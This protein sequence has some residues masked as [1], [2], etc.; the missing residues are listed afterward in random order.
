M[1]MI[2]QAHPLLIGSVPVGSGRGRIGIT[3]CPGKKQKRAASGSW[4]CHLPSDLDAIQQWG[5]A[6]VVTLLEDHELEALGVP[7]IGAEVRRRHM[8]WVHLPIADGETPCP[9]FDREWE[10]RGEDLRA[11]LRAGFDVLVHCKGGF[12]RAGTIAAK[13]LVELD[14]DPDSAIAAVRAARPEAIETAAQAAYVRIAYSWGGPIPS[15]SPQARHDRARGALIGLAVGD[16]LGTTLKLRARDTYPA[17][18]EIIGGG[19]FCLKP[20]QWTD[21]TAMALA[22]ADSLL[23]APDLDER[24]LMTRFTRW[25]EHGTYSC[26]GSCFDVGATVSQA[27]WRW[28]K[29][30]NPVSGSKDPM[31]A[32]NGALMRL[33][34]VAIRHWG[35]GEKLVAVARRQT[36]TTHGAEEALGASTYFA[37]LL[38]EAIEGTDRR[39]QIL[40]P[41]D[42]DEPPAL[43]AVIGGSWRGKARGSIQSSGYVVHSLEAALWAVGRTWSFRDAVLLA[44]NLGD[45]TDSVAAI[46]GQL[47]GAL[48]GYSGIPR[49]W[50]ERLKWRDKLELAADHLFEEGLGAKLSRPEDWHEG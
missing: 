34:P 29:F 13:L 32:G 14:H 12:G 17:L 30:G 33:A 27:L 39:D 47:A 20:G 25:R 44:A 3:F 45:D 18:E 19:P 37:A 7:E 5:A 23:A 9:R 26:T 43:A 8:Q 35:N 31:T 28:K 4:H 21:D 49:E 46:T 41:R 42:C 6:V 15:S 1:Y 16:A 22:L 40:R 24:D 10:S 50:R 38:A 48:Y 36:A 11:V 2:S